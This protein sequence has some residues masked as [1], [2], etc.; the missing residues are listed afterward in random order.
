MPSR[1]LTLTA[2]SCSIDTAKMYRASSMDTTVNILVTHGRLSQ[3]CLLARLC[4]TDVSRFSS[5]SQVAGAAGLLSTPDT[6]ASLCLSSSWTVVPP[7]RLTA[8]GSLALGVLTP[9]SRTAAAGAGP[10]LRQ[11]FH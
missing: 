1:L 4:R 3:N 11:G 2:T 5:L 8:Q 7:M 9:P 10:M 6:P